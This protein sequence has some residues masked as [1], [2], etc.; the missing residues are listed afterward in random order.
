[1]PRAKR[2]T[3]DGYPRDFVF[4]SREDVDAYLS[5]DRIVCLRCGNA[6]KL[7]DAHLRNVHNM[8][9]D[10]YRIMYGLPH[11][12]GLCSSL[13]SDQRVEHGKTVF[14]SNPARQLAALECAKAT[15]KIYGNPQRAKPK[16]WKLERTKYGRAHYEEFARRVMAGRA[17]SDVEQDDDMPSKANV[18][19][20][21]K[22]DPEFRGRWKAVVEPLTRGWKPLVKPRAMIDAIIQEGENPSA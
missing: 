17:G 14:S 2:K 1:M 18:L 20:Y 11:S 5:G 15:Q 22:R 10:D 3:L 21:M 8:T 9:S 4:A 6:F 13:L 16:F 7:L 19:W 12:R